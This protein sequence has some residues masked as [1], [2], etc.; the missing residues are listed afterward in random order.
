[1]I[2][3]LH[4]LIDYAGLFP[5]ATLP[6]GEAIQHY[7]RY[8]QSAERWMLSRFIIPAPKLAALSEVAAELFTE[9]DPFVFSVLGRGGTSSDFLEGLQADLQA[10]DAFRQRHASGV[11]LDVFEVRLPADAL[12]LLEQT[13]DLLAAQQLR[14]F[15][16]ATISAS[17]EQSIGETIAAIAAHNQR[18][19]PQAGF[20][21]R[22]GGT[23]AAAFPSPQQVAYAIAACRDADIAMKATAGLHHPLRHHNESVQVKMH[24]FVN[25]FA[26]SLLA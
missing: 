15:Y 21:L 23:E 1:M 9:N 10:I 16:E 25:V 7:A 8:R 26:A 24:G 17:W 3:F 2:P 6:L 19:G 18:G 4:H 13:S 12:A 5:P 11:R 22:C 14:P 20:K